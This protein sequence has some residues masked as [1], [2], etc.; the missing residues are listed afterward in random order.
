MG[1]AD[2]SA[3]QHGHRQLGDHGHVD[4]HPVALAHAQLAEGVGHPARFFQEL[5]VG[6]RALV[7]RLALPVVGDP[8]AQPVGHVAVE[9]I[10]ADVQLPA[11]EP[12][13]E[14]GPGPVEDRCPRLHP[15]KT[16]RLLG[17]EGLESLVARGPRV[18]GRVPRIGG[19]GEGRRRREGAVLA[20]QVLDGRAVA[21]GSMCSRLGSAGVCSSAMASAPTVCGGERVGFYPGPTPRPN[22]EDAVAPSGCRCRMAGQAAAEEAGRARA[23]QLG[24]RREPGAVAVGCRPDR[25]NEADRRAL[26]RRQGLALE[27]RGREAVPGSRRGRARSRRDDLVPGRQARGPR[28]EVAR[29]HRNLELRLQ[30]GMR[31]VDDRLGQA[32]LTGVAESDRRDRIETPA[33]LVAAGRGDLTSGLRATCWPCPRSAR[34]TSSGDAGERVRPVSG[35]DPRSSGPGAVP[36]PSRVVPAHRARSRT[37]VTW[38]HVGGCARL[39]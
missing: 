29:S 2:P 13:R 18:D 7:A 15:V 16:V 34:L 6:D 10:H 14:R 17:P 38:P 36:G 1:G 5:A 28:R 27:L 20:E 33:E 21:A 39:R 26:A 11:H 4:R 8:V 9:A 31:R 22:E 25:Q 32:Q 24:E 23:Q 30:L 19:G 12:L 3:G 35:S 37:C